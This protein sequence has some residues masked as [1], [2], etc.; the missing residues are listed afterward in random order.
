[1]D[2]KLEQRANIKFCVKLGKSAT[3][4]LEMLKQAYRNEA[5]SRDRWITIKEF[6]DIVNVSFGTVHAILT[7]DGNWVLHHDNAP[8]HRALKIREFFTRT[9][10]IVSSHPHYSPDLAPCNFFL[11]P[12][13][14]SNLKG[15]RFE[16]VEAI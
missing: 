14:K 8:P 13:M 15:Y 1:M 4:S 12:K 3:E 5:M 9:N 11:F 6:A 7:S 10:M 16:T 2:L